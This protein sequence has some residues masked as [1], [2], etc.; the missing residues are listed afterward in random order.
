MRILKRLEAFSFGHSPKKI[1]SSAYWKREM[2]GPLFGRVTPLYIPFYTAFDIVI[3]KASA[4]MINVGKHS[5]DGGMSRWRASND[6]WL[7]RWEKGEMI[8]CVRVRLFLIYQFD[9]PLKMTCHACLV[10]K[11]IRQ[12]AMHHSFKTYIGPKNMW[13]NSIA[14]WLKP[15]HRFVI[16]FSGTNKSWF[17]WNIL[18]E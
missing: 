18:S 17:L 2:V 4:T 15:Y 7:P 13:P 11:L 16:M 12:H 10:T 5:I 6:I 1:T 9:P 8:E 14:S 3:F